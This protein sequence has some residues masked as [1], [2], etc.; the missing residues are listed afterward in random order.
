MVVHIGN[1]TNRR[2][3][4]SRQ[5]RKFLFPALILWGLNFEM[6]ANIRSPGE[7]NGYP[8][9]YSCLENPMDREAWWLQSM[10]SPSWTWLSTNTQGQV[11]PR[12]WTHGLWAFWLLQVRDASFAI[13][14]ETKIHPRM[15][16]MQSTAS[17]PNNTR[18][19]NEIKWHVNLPVM[20]LSEDT[21]ET[22]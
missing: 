11:S 16:I 4:P 1:E 2:L 6:L 20:P 14:Q 9:L 5:E 8:L 10:G 21:I 7:G 12:T 15:G 17:L 22:I 13:I 18:Q 3:F 19:G